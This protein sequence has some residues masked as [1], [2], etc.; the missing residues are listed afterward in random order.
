MTAIDEA[1]QDIHA[2]EHRV[3]DLEPFEDG[4][5]RYYATQIEKINERLAK[6]EEP[7]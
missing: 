3:T 6:L 4:P 1:E 2:L 7:K 5:P